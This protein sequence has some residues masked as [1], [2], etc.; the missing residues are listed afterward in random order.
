MN[1]LL[2]RFRDNIQREQ[3]FGEKDRLYLAV[4]GGLDSVLLCHLCVDAGYDIHLLHMNFQLRGA[5]SDR[6]EEFV[7]SLAARLSVPCS[8][9]QVDAELYASTHRCSIQEAA[10]ELRYAWFEEMRAK[11]PQ[12][13]AWILTAHQ[14]NDNYETSLYHFVLGTGIHGIRG[15][16]PRHQK[17]IRP[18]LWASRSE[19][20]DYAEQ[21]NLEW[22]EDSSNATEKYTRNYL[23]HQIIPAL[24][25]VHPRVRENLAANIDRFRETELIFN[26][27][28]QRYRNKW[29]QARGEEYHL[30]VLAI[31]KTAARKTVLYELLKD[32][33]FSASQLEEILSLLDAENGR[34]LSSKTHRII[35]NRNWLVLAPVDIRGLTPCWVDGTGQWQLPGG[36]LQIRKRDQLPA[37][38][39]NDPNTSI[40]PA[41]SFSF[42]V[43]CRQ[44][45]PGDYFYPFGLR[46]KKKLARFFIDQKLSTTQKEQQLV[47]ESAGKIIWLPGLRLDD[48]FR[49]TGHEDAWLELTWLPNHQK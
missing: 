13:P 35:R 2:K 48:R 15:I 34:Y 8:T 1:D 45:K 43:Q 21:N 17:I 5:E 39:V 46:K 4:S 25:R 32:F 12:Q 3:L 24:E 9:R 18:L 22:V 20:V 33:G 11:D 29:M 38:W 6:D 36:L 44:W 27:A 26:D 14:Q 41:A 49:C 47:L 28:I 31:Q 30:P 10:R 16:L 23:R 40:V 42:P 7:R 19:L 37:R